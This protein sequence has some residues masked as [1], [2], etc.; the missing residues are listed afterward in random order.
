MMMMTI[1][2]L[3][4]MV[5][6]M[7]MVKSWRAASLPR[8]LLLLLPASRAG[9]AR[10]VSSGRDPDQAAT[11]C[12]ICRRF[13]KYFSQIFFGFLFKV[14]TH[15][16]SEWVIRRSGGELNLAGCDVPQ[17]VFLANTF[18][19]VDSDNNG[20]QWKVISGRW[21]EHP[22]KVGF[23]E[24]S[25]S[26]PHAVVWPLTNTAKH[27]FHASKRKPLKVKWVDIIWGQK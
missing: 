14:T 27:H 10:V 11:L 9:S 22:R 2:I 13:E 8:L 5:I 25:L 20:L 6:I 3:V 7:L 15:V 1:M 4:I 16:F 24:Q 23:C 18:V 21:F 12:R 17:K 19:F 26:D